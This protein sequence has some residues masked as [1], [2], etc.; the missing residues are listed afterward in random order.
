[1]GDQ[2]RAV[3]DAEL[4]RVTAFEREVARAVTRYAYGA[5]RPERD[6]LLERRA[7][8]LERAVANTLTGDVA[9][10]M[11]PTP[12]A[13]GVERL[14][15]RRAVDLAFVQL[16]A[17][18]PLPNGWRPW[19]AQPGP[20][21][22][23]PGPIGAEKAEMPS[24]T[25]S[26]PGAES[27]PAVIGYAADFSTQAYLASPDACRA[28]VADVVAAWSAAYILGE[29]EAASTDAATFEAAAAALIAGGYPA[30]L[31]VAP[32]GTIRATDARTGVDTLPAT[33]ADTYLVGRSGL[34]VLVGEVT[35]LERD[36]P[37]T[38]DHELSGIR[39][40]V[41]EVAAGAVQK[42]AAGP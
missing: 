5:P 16:I 6:E 23:F 24:S 2:A 22:P 27:T 10:L 15:Q 4:E 42:I 7:G 3:G 33:S 30:D 35:E 19:V 29:L 36:D 40:I 26:V 18:G 37:G 8:H 38:G 11:G 12:A 21:P 31:L 20:V 14:L 39:G 32:A 13:G 17:T 41:V 1:M 9:G 25:L 28:L 34:V